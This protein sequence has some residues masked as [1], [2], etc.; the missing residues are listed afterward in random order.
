MSLI[1]LHLIKEFFSGELSNG[2]NP[3]ILSLENFQVTDSI[4]KKEITNATAQKKGEKEDCFPTLVTNIDQHLNEA[5]TLL[6]HTI[7]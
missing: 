1:A 2:K 7:T 3:Q 4:M 5:L 6:I